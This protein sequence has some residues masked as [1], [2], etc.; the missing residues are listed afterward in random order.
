MALLKYGSL[1]ALA[2]CAVLVGC[3]DNKQNGTSALMDDNETLTKQLEDKNAR[4][5]ELGAQM[6]RERDRADA[7]A[8]QLA[9]CQEGAASAPPP[10]TVAAETQDFAGIPGVD[11]RVE[12]SDLYLTIANSLLFDSGKT[13]LKDSSKRTLD[14][15]AT[16]IKEL[17]PS[18]QIYVV[19]HTDNDP[20]RKSSFSTN[21]HLGF[22]RAYRVREY[23]GKK[24]L[25]NNHMALM[26]YGPDQP[27]GTK[28][29]SRRVE[30]VVTGAEVV[31]ASSKTEAPR[32]APKAAAKEPAKTKAAPAKST[33][34][35][36]AGKPAT[37]KSSVTPSK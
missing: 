3:N 32:N 21:Y 13:A 36:P 11:A 7:L 25:A 19:G 20:I 22:E 33:A 16:K 17:Y 4:L 9:E 8:T 14:Q 37:G 34:T 6:Q 2:L 15:V 27:Q 12:G 28:D 31:A 35:K 29:G 10:A 1:P 30:I 23:L 5:N 26:S 24:G 18:R